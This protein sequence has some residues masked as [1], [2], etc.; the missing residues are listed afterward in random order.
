ME[1][2]KLALSDWKEYK[3]LRLD[4]LKQDGEAFGD[5]F[6]ESAE[7]GDDEWKKELESSKSFMLVARE[8]KLAIAM[9]GAYQEDSEKMKH[10]AY[11]WG[12]YVKKAYRKKGVGQAIVK[13]LIAEIAAD[14][15][16]EKI[17]LNVS[18]GQL[19]AVRLYEKLGFE[20]AGT[21]HREM[22]VA[23]KYYDE[24]FMEKFLQK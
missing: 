14:R 7:L 8:G 20:I 4:A 3:E 16:I 13:A 15:K 24:Y 23:G 22:K 18:T 19:S 2:V 12:V 11:I 21:L 1:I 9:A 17:D 6:E 5:S 10:V